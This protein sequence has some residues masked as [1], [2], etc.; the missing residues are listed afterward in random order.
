MKIMASSLIISWQTEGE[1]MKTVTDF[2]FLSSKITAD[3]G[4]NHEIKRYLLL[5]RSYDQ[6]RQHIKKQRHYFA[7]RGPSS[8]SYDV[9]SSHVWMWELDYRESWALNNWC[10]WIVVLE[11][12]LRIPWTARRSNQSVLKEIS[13]EY[14]SEGLM[15]KL[16]VQYFGHLI[17]RNDSLEKT[18]MLGKIGGRRRKGWQRMR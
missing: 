14:S 2:I 15:L 12:T 11:K 16:K 3:G 18:R 8:Q 13:P 7:N 9:S 6:P 10:F 4:C 1:A 5:E 17:Q